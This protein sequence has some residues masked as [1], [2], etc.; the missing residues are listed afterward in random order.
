MSG[1]RCLYI[2]VDVITAALDVIKKT[3]QSSYCTNTTSK[4]VAISLFGVKVWCGYYVAAGDPDQL[5]DDR[6]RA[7]RL[8]F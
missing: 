7:E 8:I 2:I 4:P 3:K 6:P 1:E 5:D